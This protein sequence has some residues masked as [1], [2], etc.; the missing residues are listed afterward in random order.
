M[1]AIDNVKAHFQS[2]ETLTID[3]P[4][5]DLTIY[6]D[7]V[8][9]KEKNRLFKMAKNDDM[10]FF[11]HVLI[12][13]AKDE[14]GNSHFTLADKHDLMVKADTDVITRVANQILRVENDED[15]EK[16]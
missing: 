7:P 14:A 5:W 13:K 8:T 6:A 10:A 4:E 12:M 1:S 11:I 16:N 9:L 2:L 3:V 15:W